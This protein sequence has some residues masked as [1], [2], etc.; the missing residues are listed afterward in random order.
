M[1]L[2]A[3]AMALVLALTLSGCSFV[4]LDAQ[5]LMRPPKPTG[6][7]AD[8]HALLES[9]TDGKMT[10][11]YPRSGDYRSAIITHDVCGDKNDE[12]M[13]IFQKGDETSGT[14]L[15]FMKKDG[16]WTDMGFFNNPAAQV[17]K[18]CFGDVTGDGKDDVIVGWGNSLNNT[19]TICVYYYKN[20]KMNELKIDQTYTEL[21]VMDFDGDGKDEIFTASVSV[22]DQP[23]LARLLRIKDGDVEIMGSCRMDSGVTKYASAQT[24]LINEKQNGIVLDGMKSAN[25]LVTEMLY[26]DKTAKALKSPFFDSRTKTANYTVRN[27]SVVSKDINNDKII[28]VPMVSLMP[29]YNDQANNDSAYITDWNRYD[30]QTGALV[31]VMSMALDYSDGYWFLIPDMWRGR[32]TTKADTATRTV[33]F[34]E[35]KADKKKVTGTIGDALLKIQVFSESEWDGGEEAPG[36]YELMESN[37]MIFAAC[38]PSPDNPLS[39]SG[40][41]VKNSFKLMNQE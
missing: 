5:T 11:K 28:E 8:I 22:G 34:Y 20:G 2:K 32:I 23:A 27:T 39:L 7:K 21:A 6:E 25:T 26:W 10:L 17:D 3:V 19:S 15:M 31:R 1:K 40:S 36:F 37:N 13:A 29:G 18:V 24:G 9:K 33:T 30:T 12:A 35:W 14:D 38:S 16:K 41:D 4:G